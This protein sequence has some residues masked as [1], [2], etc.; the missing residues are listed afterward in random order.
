M[1]ISVPNLESLGDHRD[2]KYMASDNHVF[3][4]TSA[5][6]GSL[7]ALAGIELVAHSMEPSW[8]GYRRSKRLVCVGVRREAPLPLSADPLKPALL[9]LAAYA[10]GHAESTP[11]P[12]PRGVRFIPR[13]LRR[14]GRQLL[15]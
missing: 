13:S 6:V 10:D 4:F 7:L 12:A 3:T 11:S 2:L 14:L 5:S 8:P 1:W 15:G 9:A